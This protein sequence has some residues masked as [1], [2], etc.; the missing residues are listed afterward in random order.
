MEPIEFGEL[1]EQ[2]LVISSVM[3]RARLRTMGLS[4]AT[5]TRQEARR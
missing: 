4:F 1:V 5:I 3:G 2:L